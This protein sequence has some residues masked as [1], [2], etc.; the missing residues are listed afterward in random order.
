MRTV[1][2]L[3][4]LFWWENWGPMSKAACRRPDKAWARAQILTQELVFCGHPALSL[5]EGQNPF[6]FTRKTQREQGRFITCSSVCVICMKLPQI[7]KWQNRWRRGRNPQDMFSSASEGT[8]KPSPPD[9]GSSSTW[10]LV[11]QALVSSASRAVI[12]TTNLYHHLQQHSKSLRSWISM[13]LLSPALPSLRKSTRY[14]RQT[15]LM[16][17]ITHKALSM[18]DAHSGAD[19]DSFVSDFSLF[20]RSS[21][22]RQA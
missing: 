10:R 3:L 14:G 16:D 7:P 12:T 1:L 2:L 11:C 8:S 4:P 18:Q 22:S 19:E 13:A 5:P 6:N 17:L 20:S 15:S 21:A 9:S